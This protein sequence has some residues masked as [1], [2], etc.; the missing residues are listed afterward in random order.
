M[1]HVRVLILGGSGMLGHRVWQLFRERFDAVATVRARPPLPLFA[2]GRV[3]DGVDVTDF[4]A[5][6]KL[7]DEVKPDVVVNCAGVV[8]QLAAAHNP[9]ASITTNSLLPHIVA[10][11][12]ARLIHVSTDCVFSGRRGH[13]AESDVPDPL[14]LYGRSK[15]LGEVDAPHLTLRT[16]IIGRELQ[17]GH[18][19]VEWLLANRAGRVRGFTRARFSGVTTVE[20]ARVIAGVIEQHP[21][22]EGL[23]H[24][25]AEPISKYDLVMLLN[26]SF[27][28]GIEIDPDETL[29]L[30]RTLDG[31][32]FAAATGW[33]A[34]SWIEMTREL[35]ADG[36]KYEEWRGR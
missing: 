7:L 36:A 27:G 22:L 20:L 30:D 1:R 11:R 14:D 16:S 33:T 31:A 25:A 15:L 24:V 17:G 5:L 19:L 9:I 29:V 2:D 32:R 8:K 23:Y 26:A 10:T 21:Q 18:G 28:A 4:A 34:P 3:R 6:N 35:A 12:A 13:Y